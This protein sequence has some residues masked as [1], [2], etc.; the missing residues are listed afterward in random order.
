MIIPNKK[1][2]AVLKHLEPSLESGVSPE[3]LEMYK[4]LTS[5][6]LGIQKILNILIEGMGKMIKTQHEIQQY[7]KAL[8]ILFGINKGEG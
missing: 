6:I 8:D 4:T 2:L 3:I 7:T 5:E 1:G